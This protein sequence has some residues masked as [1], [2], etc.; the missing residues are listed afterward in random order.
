MTMPEPLT[1]TVSTKGQVILPKDVRERR[2]WGSGTR[3]VV[4][5]T[6]EGVLLRPAPAFPPTT[7]D[8]VFGMLQT[9]GP[10]KTLEEMDAAVLAEASRQ[11]G[12][13]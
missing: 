1:T 5:E 8:S 12:R 4:E 6:A 10:A 13:D 11:H 3:L 2:R 7:L 9:S